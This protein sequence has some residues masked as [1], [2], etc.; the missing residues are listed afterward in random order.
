MYNISKNLTINILINLKFHIGSNRY[1]TNIKTI[2]YI[3][4][5]R[6]NIS[7][8]HVEK[9][10]W[11]LKYFYYNFIQFFEESNTLFINSTKNQLPLK[12]YLTNFNSNALIKYKSY[13]KLYINGFLNKKWIYGIL[14][15]W[16]E[17]LLKIKKNKNKNIKSK[18]LQNFLNIIK[19]KNNSL[20]FPD[21]I[22]M[23]QQDKSALNEILRSRLPIFGLIDNADNPYFY[24]SFITANK[25]SFETIE[26]LFSILII[27]LKNNIFKEQNLFYKMLFYKI[28][29]IIKKNN[30]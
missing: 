13:N 1:L 23:L 20:F 14:S 21:F 6:N 28:K 5:Y 4:G 18:K 22:L 3:F 7:I 19:H 11:R 26:F 15:N 30:I 24:N 29:N 10:F 27:S 17:L 12:N 9:S 16:Q 25:S 8:L 2:S